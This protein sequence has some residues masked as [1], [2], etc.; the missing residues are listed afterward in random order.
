[1]SSIHCLLGLPWW[2]K[3]SILPSKTVSAKF[4]ALPLVTCPKYC[5]FIRANFPINSLSRPISEEK[6]QG[7]KSDNASENIPAAVLR[8]PSRCCAWGYAEVV[9]IPPGG[10]RRKVDTMW[11]GA[12][13]RLAARHQGKMWRYEWSLQQDGLNGAPSHT[14][15]NTE[16]CSMRTFSSLI[17]TFCPPNS[18]DFNTVNLLPGVLFSRRSTIIKVS[19]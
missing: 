2:R 17:Q 14:A 1:M 6:H 10:I 7:Q 16:T 11:R 15:R 8:C 18:P 4:P 5:S 12:W 3:P 13:Q 9:F 19:P